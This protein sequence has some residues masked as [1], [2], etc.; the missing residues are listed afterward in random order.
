MIS[1]DQLRAAR[2]LLGMTQAELATEA[3]V[4]IPTLKR[5]E[6]SGVG[7]VSPRVISNVAEALR[8]LGII[9]V[10]ADENHG[11]GVRW[12]IKKTGVPL[13]E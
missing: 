2:S 10:D 1:S 13:V 7:P 12:G 5:A 9:F 4:S 11:P 6:G 8:R 3:G